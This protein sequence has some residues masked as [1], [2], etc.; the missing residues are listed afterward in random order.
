[1]ATNY[2]Y[3]MAVKYIKWPNKIA[4]SSFAKASKIYPNREFENMPSG[5]PD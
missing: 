2:K 1:M 3:Q 5:K 4:T